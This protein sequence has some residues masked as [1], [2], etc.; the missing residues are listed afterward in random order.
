MLSWVSTVSLGA[1]SDPWPQHSAAASVEVDTTL[2]H[3]PPSPVPLHCPHNSSWPSV[4]LS[5]E[6]AWLQSERQ[7][8]QAKP[9]WR[10]PRLSVLLAGISHFIQSHT[11]IPEFSGF[12]LFMNKLCVFWHQNHGEMNHLN[13]LP[14]CQSFTSSL[15]LFLVQK[16]YISWEDLL[17]W[18]SLLDFVIYAS[19]WKFSSQQ[20]ETIVKLMVEY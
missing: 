1:W 11:K 3:S 2:T 13:Q 18:F 19:N 10:L 15:P 17:Q 5:N 8:K 14:S 6:P 12:I 9:R 16:C 20:L 7:G 4:V